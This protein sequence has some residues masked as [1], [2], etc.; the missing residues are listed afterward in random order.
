MVDWIRQ[1]YFFSPREKEYLLFERSEAAR[2]PT[3]KRACAQFRPSGSRLDLWSGACPGL[4]L[5]RTLIRES[6]GQA[7]EQTS[8]R[9]KQTLRPIRDTLQHPPRPHVHTST[10]PYPYWALGAR[11]GV[12][13]GGLARC[14]AHAVVFAYISHK[15]TKNHANAGVVISRLPFF[16]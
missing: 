5:S 13:P 16:R 2:V 4:S 6:G 10:P 9:H 15:I 14:L 7:K 8:W 3:L 12:T 11:E 1:E